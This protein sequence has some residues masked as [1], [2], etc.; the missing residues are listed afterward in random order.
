MNTPGDT[1]WSWLYKFHYITRLSFIP[2]ANFSDIGRIGYPQS[3]A[4]RATVTTI[5]NI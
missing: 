4:N 3:E 2:G 5:S 1:R